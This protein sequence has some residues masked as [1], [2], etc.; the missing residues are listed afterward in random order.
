MIAQR[1]T[2]EARRA[3]AGC[4]SLALADFLDERLDLTDEVLNPAHVLF[5]TGCALA[6]MAGGEDLISPNNRFGDRCSAN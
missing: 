6:G 3:S 5:S 4:T 2:G 1:S